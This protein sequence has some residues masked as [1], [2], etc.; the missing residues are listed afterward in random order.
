MNIVYDSSAFTYQKIGGVSRYYYE[1]ITHLMTFPS[2]DKINISYPCLN[3]ENIFYNKLP[4]ISYNPSKNHGK[5]PLSDYFNLIPGI[6]STK[7]ILDKTKKGIF[8]PTFLYAPYFTNYGKHE[9]VVT[10]L[11]LIFNTHMSL[12]HRNLRYL[13]QMENFKFGY[14]HAT[15]IIAISNNTKKE[16]LECYE[17]LSSDMV[18]VIHLGFSVRSDQ[19]SSREHTLDGVGCSSEIKYILYVGGRSGYK[20]FSFFLTS[21]AT[22]L[23]ESKDL[24]LVC[25]GGGIFS[26]EEVDLIRSLTLVD[27]IIHV[28]P[29]DSELSYLYHN[30]LA[31][32]CP[33]L[34]EGFGL[35][36]LEAYANSCPAILNNVSCLPEIGGNAALYFESGNALSLQNCIY[37]IYDNE[38]LRENLIYKGL[39]QVQKFSWSKCAEETYKTYEKALE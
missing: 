22:I 17:N 32:V 3:L 5:Y 35:P 12:S 28:T 30:A 10:C 24:Y 15:R 21:I 29:T 36:I 11:D 16:L 23:T 34:H 4:N 25:V 37:S 7:K 38:K 13:L 26:E 27:K 1:L 39:S 33:S 2:A 19:C 9:M 14:N 18:D 8:H 20:N 31:Y 6:I